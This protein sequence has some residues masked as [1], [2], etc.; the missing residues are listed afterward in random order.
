MSA[1]LV[2]SEMC[3]RDRASTARHAQCWW[4][5]LGANAR[6]SGLFGRQATALSVLETA[7]ARS[8]ALKALDTAYAG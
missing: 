7:G 5:V 4:G 6:R 3:I 1:S 8:E 2:G